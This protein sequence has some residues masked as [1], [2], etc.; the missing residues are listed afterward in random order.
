M[1]AVGALAGHLQSNGEPGWQVLG[2]GMHD[3]FL[4]EL[5]YRAREAAEK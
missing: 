3:L 1:L 5:G 2:R 4:P